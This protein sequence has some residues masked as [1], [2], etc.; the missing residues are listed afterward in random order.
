LTGS[1]S[2][3]GSTLLASGSFQLGNGGT[4]GSLPGSNTVQG[5][6]GTSL[7]FDSSD[8]ITVGNSIISGIGLTQSGSG[9]LTL[10]AAE[11]YSGPTTVTSGALVVNGSI[12]GSPTTVSGGTLGGNGTLGAVSVLSGGAILPATSGT[13]GLLSLGNFSLASGATFDLQLDGT[14]G[15]GTAA[16]AYDELKTAGTVTLGGSVQLSIMSVSVRRAAY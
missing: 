13:V 10:T 11:N 4:T 14:T 16:V 3:L 6:S 9:S 2:Y 1:N 12:S 15:T 8:N 5:N 7:I